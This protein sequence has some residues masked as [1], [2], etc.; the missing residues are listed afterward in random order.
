M[1]Q[2]IFIFG[3]LTCFSAEAQLRGTEDMAM[4]EVE[5]LNMEDK[6]RLNDII[7]FEGKSTKKSFKGITNSSGKFEIL[8][9]EGDIYNIKIQGLGEADEYSTIR[10]DKQ[11]GVIESM[12]QIK[13]DPGKVFTL[14]NVQ[15]NSGQAT[16]RSDSYAALNDL[17]EILK[18][19]STMV[20]EIGGHTD[21][22]GDEQNNL[23]LSEKR[24]NAVLQ[25]LIKK[26]IDPKRLT[27]IGYGETK[28]VAYNDSPEG[29][30]KNRRTEVTV[31]SE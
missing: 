21:D 19:K 12:I 18:I 5:V 1:K 13:Y 26:G 14:Q 22:V 24:A 27:A 25:Y 17:V 3:L 23:T 31:V 11:D 2:I 16:L 8:L 30:Q 4:L 10:I 6:P 15:F 29:R 7:I 20:I 28:P 9:P